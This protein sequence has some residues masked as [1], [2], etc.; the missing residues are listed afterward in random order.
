[1]SRDLFMLIRNVLGGATNLS[2]EL[3]I[4]S[5]DIVFPCARAMEGGTATVRRG[6]FRQHVD[7]AVKQFHL[8]GSNERILIERQ[9]RLLSEVWT[10]HELCRGQPK[11]ILPIHGV[12]ISGMDRPSSFENNDVSVISEWM[13]NGTAVDYFRKSSEPERVAFV[14]S[15]VDALSWLHDKRD[16]VH[17]DIKGVNI[18]VDAKGNPRLA[19]FG[20]TLHAYLDMD[21][22]IGAVNTHAG[23]YCWM[24]PERFF[25][26]ISG[27][28]TRKPTKA[29]DVYSFAML[30]IELYTGDLPMKHMGYTTP[31]SL[32]AFHE[33]PNSPR[34]K[35]PLAVPKRMWRIV[36]KCAQRDEKMRPSMHEVKRDMLEYDRSSSTS[37]FYLVTDLFRLEVLRLVDWQGVLRQAIDILAKPLMAQDRLCCLEIP[38]SPD[39]HVSLAFN[40]S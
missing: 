26:A 33:N 3:F 28:N 31:Q 17:G 8:K 32:G 39:H 21:V 5:Q 37:V 23:S 4:R 24:A 2:P 13:P 11:E 20:L 1:M 9:N 25:P 35:R 40:T 22:P 34:L 16:I 12:L 10:W 18:L 38:L 6:V 14:R 15:I 7:V 36:R 29:S 27:K 30:V 19:D